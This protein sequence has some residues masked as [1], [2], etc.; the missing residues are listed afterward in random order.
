MTAL[1]VFRVAAY[2]RSHRVYQS[3]LLT[4]AML[5]ILH[6]SRAPRGEEA[7]VLA[8]TAILIIPILAWA[9][10]SLLDTEPDQQREMS[11]VSVGGRGRELAAGLVAAFA[12]CAVL[13]AVGLA[14]SLLLGVSARPP[15]G[16]LAAGV[17]LHAL[18]ALVGTALGALTSRAVVPSPALSIMGLVF[19][20]LL[21]LLLSLSPAYWLTVPLVVWIRAATDGELLARF[22]E[23]AAISLFWCLLAL[24]WY[25]WR[26]LRS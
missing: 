12:A 21:M 5:A 6:G 4:L 3:L 18:A 17:A 25:A 16:V 22:P 1:A 15:S 7:N 19:G 23:L 8:T 20:F 2:V 14:A 10:R 13:A 9:A 26:R 11:A 24:A